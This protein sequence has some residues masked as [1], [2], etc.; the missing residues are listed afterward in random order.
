VKKAFAWCAAALMGLFLTAGCGSDS[1]ASGSQSGTSQVYFLNFKPEVSEVYAEIA[2]AYRAETGV[3]IKVET[4]SAG[5]YESTLRSEIAKADAPTIFQING[6]VGYEGWSDY[7]LDLSGTDLYGTLIDKGL[8]VTSGGG[9]YGIPYVVEGYGIIYNDAVMRDYFA[10]PGAAAKSMEEID[11]FAKLKALVEDMS[12]KKDQLGIKG[13]FAST[14]MAAGEQWRWQSH[15]A[16][17]PLYY[18]LSENTAYDDTVWAG[19]AAES[20]AFKY[21]QNFKN[22]FDLYTN[23]SIS[24]KGLLANVSVSSSLA[25]FALG[26]AAMIQNGNWGAAQIMGMAGNVVQSEDIKFLPIYT[27]M[28]GEESQ[29]LCVGTENFLAV[30]S[31]VSPERQEASVAFLEWLFSSETGKS[32]VVNDLMFIA[33]FDTFGDGEEPDDPLAREVLAWMEKT[34]IETMEWTFSAFPSEEF[35]NYFGDALL[36]YVQGS[37]NWDYVVKVVVDSWASERAWNPVS[38]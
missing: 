30:N 7:C 4:A 27:G 12:V 2:A 21:N 22:T 11:S 32:F 38:S 16:N 10:L 31:Q 6:P 24:R 14:S 17:I 28:A 18:E 5:M 3:A 25:E 20:I 35:K 26:Q 8:A 23:H 37:E 19:L 1:E 33:P 34:G 13:V 9:V 15:L 29:G 36:E